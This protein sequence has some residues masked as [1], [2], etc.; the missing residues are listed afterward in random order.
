MTWRLADWRYPATERRDSRLDLLRGF[1]VFAMICDHVAG[2]SWFSPVTGANRFVT[3]AA[4]GFVLLAGLVLGMVYGPRIA[5]S[6]WNAAADPILRRT[7]VLYGVTV[8]LTLLFVALFQ[9]TELRLWLD[10]AYGLGLADPIQ[11]VL[12]TLTL[13][14]V[15]HGTDILLLYCV[16]IAVAPLLLLALFRGYWLAVLA[17]SWLV[18]LGHQFYPAEVM[19]PWTVTN[20]YYFP[21]AAWQVIFVTALV[22]GYYREQVSAAMRRVPITVWLV[23]FALG[24]TALVLIQRA[25]DR[26][27]L[28]AWPVLG[29]LA[30]DLYF[31]V[32]DKPSVA[33]GRLLA[34]VLMA[35][36]TY[37]LVTVFWV[38]IRRAFGWLLF[39]LGTNSLR[40]YGIHLIVIVVVYNI[41]PIARLYDR[42]RTGNT[43]LQVITVG[44]TYLTVVGWKWLEQNVGWELSPRALPSLLAQPRHRALIGSISGGLT[45]I[46]VVTAILAGPVR[47][48]RTADPVE[49][50]EEV[51]I[52]RSVPPDAAADSPLTVLL[53]VP[54]ENQ[55]GPE[56]AA[57]FL[58]EAARR[59]WAVV[60]PTLVYGDWN[61][62][63]EATSGMLTNLPLLRSL[64]AEESWDGTSVSP[65]V[66]IVGEGRGAHTA[67]A[68]SLFY[69][70][71]TAAVAT[72]GPSPC[73][74]PATEQ[75]ET[76]EMPALPFPYGISDLE[77]YTGEDIDEGDLT[78]NA[79]WLGVGSTDEV[80]AGACSWGAMAGRDP[81][82][83]ARIFAGLVRRVGARAE[84]VVAAPADLSGLRAD[85]LSFLDTQ[86][87]ASDGSRRA[88][89][90]RAQHS[91]P[92]QSR[93]SPLPG[94]GT[95]GYRPGTFRL[96][97]GPASRCPA[98]VHPRRASVQGGLPPPDWSFDAVWSPGRSTE[99]EPCM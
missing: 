28:A 19:I 25:H 75:T 10:R 97:S 94:P 54:G 47:A 77:Q 5:R 63:D 65:R 66:L 96:H 32:F 81:E 89:E 53:V 22:V 50:M 40:A 35:G 52:L 30:G 8:G 87:G 33:I 73:I 43:I 15:Y 34:T 44:L 93:C 31:L 11:L 38:P 21:V 83:R 9:F 56:A 55:T 64:V 16:L 39:A 18:W 1:A 6:G 76:G 27:Q 48:S 88:S 7:A 36:F 14:F 46:A 45:V 78:E 37:S 69:P 41:D 80:E 60:A 20:A 24:V 4:E 62:P 49:P 51:G 98:G 79:L 29:L 26:G 23:C 59:R 42:S 67:L 17:A 2:I 91:A 71:E 61:D 86:S 85:A 74:L 90:M 72:I 13:H 70:D 82:D 3:S 57:P 99:D 84:V 95:D 92:C 12:G 68:F 58:D